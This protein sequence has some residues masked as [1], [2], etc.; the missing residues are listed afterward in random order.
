MEQERNAKEYSWKWVTA[1]EI[2]SKVACDLCYI[3]VVPSGDTCD[4]DIYDGENTNGTPI[5]TMTSAGKY[6]CE[7]H[8]SAPIYCRRG[9]YIDTLTGITGILV[10]WRPRSSQEG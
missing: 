2:L 9:L 3:K 1:A 4:V 8:P 10:Q 5:I 7:M 6:S